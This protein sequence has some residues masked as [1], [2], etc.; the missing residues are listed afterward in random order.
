M[1]ELIRNAQADKPRKPPPLFRHFFNQPLHPKLSCPILMLAW[2]LI[3]IMVPPKYLAME[4]MVI[5]IRKK[6][7]TS[8]LESKQEALYCSYLRTAGKM[9]FFEL[10]RKPSPFTYIKKKLSM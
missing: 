8:G 2:W 5:C 6:N 1:I 3:L 10:T 7:Y 9:S 4:H